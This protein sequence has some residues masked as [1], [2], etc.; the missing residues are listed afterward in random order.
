MKRFLTLLITICLS[1][2]MTG[3]AWAQKSDDDPLMRA[4]AAMQ[5]GD[6]DKAITEL[7]KVIE[8]QPSNADAYFL[9]S[10]LKVTSGD[11]AGA[12]ADISKAIE[13]KSDVGSYYY[14]RAIVRLTG[15]DT[16]GAKK[17]L[18]LAL[19]NNYKIDPVYTLRAQLSMEQ[20][21]LK[22]A[23]ADLDEAI[24][25]NPNNPRSY[26]TRADLLLDLEDRDR[27]FADLNYLL[28]W[29]ETD[30]T[31]RP[32]TKVTNQDNKQA[33]GQPGRPDAAV[34]AKG[35][36]DSDTFK[37][38]VAT[39]TVNE[40]PAD[41]EMIP[42]IASAY[43]K[44]GLIY[45]LRDKPDA[46]IADFTKSI[47][48]SPDDAWAFFSR[49]LELEG[50]GDLTGALSDIRKTIELEPRNGNA[51]VEHGVILLL[52]GRGEEAQAVFDVLLKSDPVLWQK[53]I[54]ERTVAARKKLSGRPK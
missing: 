4:I 27:A 54:D 16:A 48:I 30:P 23:L 51:R 18:D 52:L 2:A 3:V 15:K 7:T 34:N 6:N 20:G 39:E 33:K 11:N 1:L 26:L 35:Q 28:T 42:V 36:A 31:K 5:A 49:A 17:D 38:E 21:D 8:L 12:L 13:L 10:N 19:A 29:Y 9:R 22:G 32:Q 47:R 50:K 37:V 53:R 45:S 25:L 14:N 44:R 24:K 46:A 43:V 40:S 41:K